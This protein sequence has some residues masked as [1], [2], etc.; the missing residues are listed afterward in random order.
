MS[1]SVVTSAKCVN[2]T[3]NFSRSFS[4][5]QDHLQASTIS[6]K[7]FFFLVKFKT[8]GKCFQSGK[9]T[10]NLLIDNLSYAC[11]VYPLSKFTLP[12]E[13]VILMQST[14]VESSLIFVHIKWN[15]KSFRVSFSCSAIIQSSI[16]LCSFPFLAFCLDATRILSSN[17]IEIGILLFLAV[18]QIIFNNSLSWLRSLQL[19]IETQ[20]N[21]NKY[22]N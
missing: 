4:S 19:V 7:A 2:F 9:C 8:R 3:T 14:S 20:T 6:P 1:Q 13:N 17:E 16:W 11:D 5:S 10:H 22:L 15:A 21:E 12:G 18:N